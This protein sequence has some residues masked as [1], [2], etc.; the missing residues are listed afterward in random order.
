MSPIIDLQRRIVES[1][2]IRI[3]HQVA[4]SGGRSRPEKLER[5]RLTSADR[6][7]IEQAAEAYGGTVAEWQAP[8]GRQWEVYTERDSLDVIVPPS[9]LAFSQAYELWSGGGCKRRCDG[10]WETL[11]DQACVCDPVARE[12]DIHTRLSVMLRDL[13]GL[14]VWRIDTQGYYAATELS[15]AV[16]VIQVAA[17]RGALLPARL[18]L[19]QRSVK[20]PGKDGKPQ[21]L[22]FAVPVLDIEITPTQLLGGVLQPLQLA[23]TPAPLTPVP[24]LPGPATPSIAEQSGPPAARPRRKNAAPELPASGRSRRITEQPDQAAPLPGLVDEDGAVTANAGDRLPAGPA[25][26]SSPCGHPVD[27]RVETRAGVVCSECG[28][29]LAAE[30]APAREPKTPDDDGYWP[31][32][33]HAVAAEHDIDHVGL[34]LV[35]AALKRI[36]P[37]GIAEWSMRSLTDEEWEALDKLMR[38][39]PTPLTVDAVTV[40]LWPIATA[41]GL[42]DWDAVDP[43]ATAAYGKQPDELGVAEWIAFALRLHAGEYDAAP[44][45]QPRVVTP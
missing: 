2:R 31:A 11:S 45:V 34:H 42:A 1:G 27:L 18:R 16:Q 24:Q 3:G 36:P 8:S 6:R 29:K 35:G 38:R 9:D 43:L 21:T 19:E 12:C 20:R 4:T 37:E 39:L 44:P 15:G 33:V 25:S 26:S 10:A 22:R 30:E 14:G 28:E 41:K 5:F 7:R 13:P 17:G 40:W 32:R 23:D